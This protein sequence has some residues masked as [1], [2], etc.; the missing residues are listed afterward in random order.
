[1]KLFYLF[2]LFQTINLVLY[3]FWHTQ[4][5]LSTSHLFLLQKKRNSTSFCY[6][7]QWPLARM[8]KNQWLMLSVLMIMSAQSLAVDPKLLIDFNPNQPKNASFILPSLWTFLQIGKLPLRIHLSRN[9]W[10]LIMNH[11]QQKPFLPTL[12]P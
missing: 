12:H 11:P 6:Q 7:L 2:D 3:K 10:R 4:W 8:S 5:D 1:M 9:I